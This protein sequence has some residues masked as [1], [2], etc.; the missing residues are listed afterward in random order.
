[1][2]YDSSW[3]AQLVSSRTVKNA[4]WAY[5]S[6]GYHDMART[7]TMAEWE[8][9]ISNYASKFLSLLEDC[10]N[11]ILVWRTLP[12]PLNG[13]RQYVPSWNSYMRDYSKSGR[14]LLQDLELFSLAVAEQR[15]DGHHFGSKFN[16]I[17]AQ[18]MLNQLNY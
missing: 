5:V 2:E 10:S 3:R 18:M 16:H 9:N 8:Y 4:D 12:I 13:W 14:Y 11:T 1:V 6:Y 7:K 17:I 15:I